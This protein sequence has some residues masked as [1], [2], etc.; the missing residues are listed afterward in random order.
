MTATLAAEIAG[1]GRSRP[2]ASERLIRRPP[3]TKPT[4][5]SVMLELVIVCGFSQAEN[6]RLDD[7][8]ERGALIAAIDSA[9]PDRV[10][11]CWHGPSANSGTTSQVTIT[12]HDD[13]RGH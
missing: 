9:A 1:C 3:T 6:L 5:M 2:A 11:P 12:T 8:E 10:E 7:R 13:K 4:S